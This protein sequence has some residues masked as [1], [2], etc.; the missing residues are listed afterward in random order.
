MSHIHTQRRARALVSRRESLL[1]LNALVFVVQQLQQRVI[2]AN[3][4]KSFA[5]EK[6]K[7]KENFKKGTITIRVCYK[8][9]NKQKTHLNLV[10]MFPFCVFVFSLFFF[11]FVQP[12]PRILL[13]IICFVCWF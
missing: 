4:S 9:V 1:L 2:I 11:C 5:L 8:F 12:R 6:E 7:R 13:L 10:R 3:C